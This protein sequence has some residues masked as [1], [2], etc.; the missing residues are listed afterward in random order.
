MNAKKILVST[1]RA[2]IKKDL[3]NARVQMVWSWWRIKTRV[4]IPMN[5][6]MMVRVT[7]EI[8][9]IFSMAKGLCVIVMMD[10]WRQLM[11]CHAKVNSSS[12]VFFTCI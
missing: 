11:A 1:G 2:S 5:V 8:V 6:K 12:L 10:S 3:L 7:M 4:S 9:Q